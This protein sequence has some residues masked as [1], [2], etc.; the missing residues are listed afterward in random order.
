ML[1]DWR[2]RRRE[3]PPLALLQLEAEARARDLPFWRRAD[4]R[5]QIGYG[6][7][8]WATDQ[9]AAEQAT[10]APPWERIGRVPIAAAESL[11][12]PLIG[13]DN[14]MQVRLAAPWLLVMPEVLH[15]LG[16]SDSPSGAELELEI[17]GRRR[18]VRGSAELKRRRPRIPPSRFSTPARSPGP[19]PA[20]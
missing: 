4:G 11:V 7:G 5:F 17:A 2:R 3:A 18:V 12:T 19:A 10:A 15:A 16:M 6:A 14:A 1:R 8:G 13:R 20:P 9:P